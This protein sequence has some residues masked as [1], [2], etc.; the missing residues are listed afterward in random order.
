M[1]DTISV[2]TVDITRHRGVPVVVVTGEVDS[3]TVEPVRTHL[4][5]QLDRR[6]RGL[7]VDLSAVDFIGSTG[8]HLL[9]EAITCAKRLGTSLAVVAERHVVLRP[10]QI[11]GLD[12]EVTVCATVD[13]AVTTVLS[14]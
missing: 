10:M 14:R 8:M 12:R 1:L 13:Q 5:D 3:S 2:T 11:T 6:P 9:A 7:V 4:F